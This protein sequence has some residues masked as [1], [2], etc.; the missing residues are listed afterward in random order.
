MTEPSDL[1]I[2]IS[3]PIPNFELCCERLGQL[4]RRREITEKITDS[5]ETEH[6]E[7]LS[8]LNEIANSPPVHC[9]FTPM[10]LPL[11]EE[12]MIPRLWRVHQRAL[13]LQRTALG[14]TLAWTRDL[15]HL[16]LPH[17]LA[18]RADNLLLG[19]ASKCSVTFAEVS[20]EGTGSVETSNSS[21]LE[22]RSKSGM[23]FKSI[24]LLKHYI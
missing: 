17:R 4:N 14:V 3:T 23:L 11:S 2:R 12:G 22:K 1:L 16:L 8:T 19:G 7:A 18:L 10:H 5:H 24:K 20:L 9:M 15:L 21:I 13:T 6:H